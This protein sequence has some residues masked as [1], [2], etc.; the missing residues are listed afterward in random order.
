M[1]GITATSPVSLSDESLSSVVYTCSAILE[2]LL[3]VEDYTCDSSFGSEP[4]VSFPVWI[5]RIVSKSEASLEC[6]FVALYYLS[7]I[8]AKFPQLRYSST[9]AHRCFLVAFMLASKFCEDCTFQNPSW[10]IIGYS[11]YSLEI[12]NAMEVEFIKLL[13]WNLHVSPNDLQGFLS[14]YKNI[15]DK[16]C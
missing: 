6:A 11:F 9:N 16:L 3:D 12:L 8:Q 14:N 10:R 13:D 1:P 4:T 5:R 7:K 15:F 2:Q